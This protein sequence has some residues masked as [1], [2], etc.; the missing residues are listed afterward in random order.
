MLQVEKLTNREKEILQLIVD[1]KTNREISK[2]LWITY[3][4]T[5]NHVS[6]ILYKLEV[7]NRTEAAIIF[8]NS[9]G[10]TTR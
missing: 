2:I 6:N 5:K 9:K 8:L 1:G 3:K 7:R 4:T 10:G